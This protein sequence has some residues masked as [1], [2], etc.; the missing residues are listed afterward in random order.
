MIE[1]LYKKLTAKRAIT[2]SPKMQPGQAR[3]FNF[4]DESHQDYWIGEIF[5]GKE[6]PQFSTPAPKP[7]TSVEEDL[8][9]KNEPKRPGRPIGRPRTT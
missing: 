7:D 8:G 2:R 1:G 6:S 9:V 4:S 3:N 5:L